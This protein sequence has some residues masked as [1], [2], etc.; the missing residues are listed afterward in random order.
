[1]EDFVMKERRFMTLVAILSLLVFSA[2]FISCSGDDGV[3]G[4]AGGSGAA[5][6]DGATGPAGADG[7]AGAAGADGPDGADGM[8]AYEIAVDSGFVGTE[9]EW[10]ASLQAPGPAS[11]DVGMSAVITTSTPDNGT[12]FV[13][14]ESIVVTIT[15]EDVDGNPLVLDDL[16][17]AGLYMNGPRDVLKTESAVELLGAGEDRAVQPHHYIDLTATDN[18]N[19][20]VDENVVTYVLNPITTEEAGTY[21]IGVW[22]QLAA[23]GYDQAFPLAD[24]QIGTATEEPLIVDKDSCADCH[25][26]AITE[27]IYLHHIDSGSIGY[28][29]LDSDPVRTC[30][31]CH[32]QDGYSS[33]RKCEDGSKAVRIDGVYT[34]ADA[35][36]NWDYMVDPIV[37]RV[38]GVH[39]GNNL[40]S[41]FNTNEVYGDF[42]DYLEVHF[43][44]DVRNCT[45]CHQDDSWNSKPS[46]LV[47]GACHDAL[48]FETGTNHPGGVQLD[49]S[50]CAVCHPATGDGSESDYSITTVHK[51]ADPVFQYTVDLDLSEPDNGE[52]YVDEA[53]VL[54][55]TIKDFTT[56]VEVDPSTFTQAAG[57]RGNLFV[58]GPRDHTVPVL[59]T[60]AEGLE[61]IRALTYSDNQ[62]FD[63]S[64]AVDFKVDIDGTGTLTI[65]VADG[66]FVDASAATTEEAVAWLNGNAAFAALATAS[67]EVSSSTETNR[68]V[69]TSNSRGTSVEIQSSDATD[70]MGWEI[71]TYLPEEHH[72]YAS[73]DFRVRT[74]PF[75]DDPRIARTA[76]DFTYQLDSVVGLEDGT[77]TI[78]LEIGTSYPVSWGLANFQVGTETEQPKVATNCLDCHEDTR[79]HAAYFAINFDTD[80]CKSCH[81]YERQMSD[82]GVDDPA[83]GWGGNAASGRSNQGFGAAPIVRRLHGVHYGHYLDKPEEVHGSYDYSGVIFP[84]DIRNCTKCHS[85]VDEWSERASRLACLACHDSDSTIAHGTLMTVD[86]T[87]EDPW[88]GDEME[89]C[90]TCHGE[91]HDFEIS[92]VHRISDPYV[93]PYP[94]DAE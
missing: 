66:T 9:E 56:G 60:A 79:M 74:D 7:A 80:I 42:G 91:G 15:M 57:G 45:K 69:I 90:N 48:D 76:T 46:R 33:V 19:Q 86:P 94:R 3:T 23:N 26:G 82:R 8:S 14:G 21:T 78:W 92:E 29:S 13:T 16:S 63:L 62:T 71:G 68:V 18:A 40:S 43:P 22:A 84:Q 4:P 35:T 72:S 73:N 85:E 6:A 49:D 41:D 28:W 87:P 50:N 25:L 10:V 36:E 67:A 77:Y 65:A 83:D 64:A 31:M 38:H 52:Y 5:G 37:R 24:V 34:C 89:S 17:R 61:G 39:N 59:S 20:S 53:P 47:C 88:N 12:H 1:M 75:D 11:G 2:V 93:K 30:K 27:K 44:A 81:D 32:N 54:T 51:V 58:S 55:V 70:A